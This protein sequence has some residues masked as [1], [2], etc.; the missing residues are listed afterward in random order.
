MGR[1]PEVALREHGGY[2]DDPRSLEVEEERA[3]SNL[4]ER[5]MVVE[6]RCLR[7]VLNALSLIGDNSSLFR[8]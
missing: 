8:S 6:S 4:K 7:C 1:V 3:Q 2:Y 5:G